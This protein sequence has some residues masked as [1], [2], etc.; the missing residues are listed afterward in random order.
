MTIT[1]TALQE[2][3]AWIQLHEMAVD[4]DGDV[5]ALLRQLDMSSTEYWGRH[6]QMRGIIREQ[7]STEEV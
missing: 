6:T 4:R 1:L 5:N 7:D 2:A 3:K